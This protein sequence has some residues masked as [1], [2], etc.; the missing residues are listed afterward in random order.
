MK[1][2]ETVAFDHWLRTR[3]APGEPGEPGEKQAVDRRSCYG[4][5]CG[6]LVGDGKWGSR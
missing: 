2:T 1:D 4:G 5:D 6:G 3:R